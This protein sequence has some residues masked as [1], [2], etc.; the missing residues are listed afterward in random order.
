[1]EVGSSR[2][3]GHS[4][5]LRSPLALPHGHPGAQSASWDLAEQH[6]S[7]HPPTQ[8]RELRTPL[9]A[10][11]EIVSVFAEVS[12]T[13]A[14]DLSVSTWSVV[15]LNKVNPPSSNLERTGFEYVPLPGLG[16]QQ[17]KLPPF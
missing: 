8:P 3:V 2:M 1:M 6:P 17:D 7:L 12:E 11:V 15:K 13:F 9:W 5:E 14:M 16:H 4:Q 10:S